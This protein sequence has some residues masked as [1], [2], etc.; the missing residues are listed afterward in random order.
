MGDTGS[1]PGSGRSPRGRNG[2]P[3][4]LFLLGESHGQRSLA[5]YSHK[6]TKSH[7]TEHVRTWLLI[8]SYNMCQSLS[9]LRYCIY[10]FIC[11]ASLGSMG[12]LLPRP[13]IEHMPP[14]VETWSLTHWTTRKFPQSLLLMYVFIYERSAVEVGET[15]THSSPSNLY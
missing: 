5:G 8:M 9:F 7:I 3:L 12:I 14:T 2:N 11:L 1:I 6:V 4:R 15:S 13:G 10:L